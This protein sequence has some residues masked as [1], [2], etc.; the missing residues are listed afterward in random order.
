VSGR[1]A[2]RGSG[3]SRSTANGS[4]RPGAIRPALTLLVG[5]GARRPRRRCTGN[6]RSP[7]RPPVG[8]NSVGRV[9]ASAGEDAVTPTALTGL[10]PARGLPI[11]PPRRLQR[12]ITT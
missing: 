9:K 5:P 4:R 10:H 3:Q 12:P 1:E 6:T 2:E 7:S 11:P 8:Q